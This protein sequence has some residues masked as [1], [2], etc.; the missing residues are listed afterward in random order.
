MSVIRK[1]MR[2]T[3]VTLAGVIA[4][5]LATAAFYS[6]RSWLVAHGYELPQIVYVGAFLAVLGGVYG[7]FAKL[8][9]R[10]VQRVRAGVNENNSEGII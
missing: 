8:A 6:L 2:L 3:L 4:A 10:E 5:F 9:L 7:A 1:Y